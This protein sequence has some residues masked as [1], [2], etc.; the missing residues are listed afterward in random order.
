MDF[1]N[2][3]R[4]QYILGQALYI[5]I[6]AMKN[7]PRPEWSNIADMEFLMKELFPLYSIT[8]NAELMKGGTNE[9]N[10]DDEE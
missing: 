4:G 6:D 5:A 10:C 1:V 3:M 7:E 2:G 8:Q 9:G